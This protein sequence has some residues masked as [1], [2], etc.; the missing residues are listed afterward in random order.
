MQIPRI[1]VEAAAIDVQSRVVTIADPAICKQLVN[2]LRMRKGERIDILDGG[3]CIYFCTLDDLEKNRGRCTAT[4]NRYEQATGEPSIKLAVAMPL[5]KSGRF[6]W[7]IEKLTELGVTEIIPIESERSVVQVSEKSSKPSAEEQK[8]KRWSA[9]A[10]EAAEQCERALIPKVVWPVK[11]EKFLQDYRSRSGGLV[12]CAE[13]KQAQSLPALLANPASRAAMAAHSSPAAGGTD[14]GQAPAPKGPGSADSAQAPS[15]A[16]TSREPS[17]VVLIGPEGGFT[18]NEF[19]LA[20]KAGAMPV[21]LGKRIL[22][23]ETA[24]VYAA[25]L[26]IGCLDK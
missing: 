2:V 15:T 10:R 3:G 18:E 21:T 22:R 7:A 4:I 13:R 19:D 14:S 6:E 1:F 16:T 20:E 24:A 12:I 26:I 17:L 8:L 23:S 5:L 25:S 11:L 9:I